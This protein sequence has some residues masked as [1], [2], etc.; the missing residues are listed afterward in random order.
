MLVAEYLKWLA[1]GTMQHDSGNLGLWL[2]F[3]AAVV[4][5]LGA[6]VAAYFAARPLYRTS[7]AERDARLMN[8][9]VEL[10]GRAQAR[11]EGREMGGAEQNA[12]IAAVAE[13]G[14][15]Y[16]DV[17]LAPALAGL[18]SMDSGYTVEEKA[19]I[20]ALADALTRLDQ[21]EKLKPK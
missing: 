4:T 13:M 8:L 21:S 6:I 20:P 16:P 10:M 7:Q 9:F 19:R 11:L 3:G 12:A 14:L 15:R 18:Q 2:L 1:F 5:A 17:L